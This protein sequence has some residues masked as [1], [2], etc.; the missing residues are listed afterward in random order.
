MARIGMM[1]GRLLPPVDNTIFHFPRKDWAKEFELAA[2]AQID[3]IEWIYDVYGADVNPLATDEGIQR[4][5]D[6]ARQN[7]VQVLSL[8][9][10]Y[11][12]ENLLVRVNSSELEQ[13]INALFWLLKQSQKIGIKRVI[14]P[15]L[16]ASRIETEAELKSVVNVLN[17]VV[18]VADQ[19]GIDILLESSLEPLRL[20]AFLAELPSQVKIN[21]D[22]GNSASLGYDPREEFKAYGPRI[23]SVHVKDRL[24][25]DGTVPLGTGN[26][27]FKIISDGLKGISYAGDFVLEAAR[28]T[29]GDELAWAKRNREFIKEHLC[30]I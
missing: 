21:Y 16:D 9:A 19:A 7:N 5:K 24:R 29:S 23:G 28:G 12:M 6:L 4:I 8:C 14:L 26:A 11:F 2:R 13:H 22:T 25:G 1:Q 20:A 10:N 30:T 3:C 27:D 17:R 15:F 18:P